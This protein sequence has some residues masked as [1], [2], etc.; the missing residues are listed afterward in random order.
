MRDG[1]SKR[2]E[3]DGNILGNWHQGVHGGEVISSRNRFERDLVRVAPRQGPE[4]LHLYDGNNT[5]RFL[6]VMIDP[7]KHS[8]F[9]VN[10]NNTE[11]DYQTAHECETP[12]PVYILRLS[13]SKPMIFR[14]PVLDGHIAE[15]LRVM[16][17]NHGQDPLPLLDF[18][19][20]C[21]KNTYYGNPRSLQR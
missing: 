9:V 20:Y 1:R 2:K 10:L 21:D 11:Y 14:N 4:S 16:H 18:D 8:Y 19:N 5:T 17:N 15:T 6:A 3:V 7:G 13:K 12:V